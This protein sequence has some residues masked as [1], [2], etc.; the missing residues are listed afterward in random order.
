MSEQEQISQLSALFDGELP[1][2]EADM[3]I[4]RALK[5]PAMRKN[6]ERYALIG[7]CLRLEPLPR[8]ISVAERVQARLTT[9]SEFNVLTMPSAAKRPDAAGAARRVLIGRGALGGAIAAGVAALS[10]LLVRQMAPAVDDAGALLTQS[11]AP[12]VANVASRAAD[13]AGLVEAG[14]HDNMPDSYT[15]PGENAPAP[16]RLV[17]PS[18]GYYLVAHSEEA[19]SALRF[20][21]DLAQAGAEMTEDESSALR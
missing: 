16:R 15:T 7:A 20:S 2:R 8:G 17:D 14:L 1:P 12:A 18:L 19:A 4:R 11:A 3:V 10:I 9:E 5:D 13:P 6:W 21:Y